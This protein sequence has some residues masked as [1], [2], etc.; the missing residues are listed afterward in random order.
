MLCGNTTC[1]IFAICFFLR[2]SS[3]SWTAP[4]EYHSKRKIPHDIQLWPHSTVKNWPYKSG[5][6]LGLND[7]NYMECDVVIDN[8]L[9]KQNTEKESNLDNKSTTFQLENAIL[10]R[11]HDDVIITN[12]LTAIEAC[13][14]FDLNSKRYSLCFGQESIYNITNPNIKIEAAYLDKRKT[15][16][17]YNGEVIQFFKGDIAKH[18]PDF[19]VYYAC[20]PSTAPISITEPIINQN[21]NKPPSLVHVYVLAP[22]FCD[23]RAMQV[24]KIDEESGGFLADTTSNRKIRYKD[25]R[26]S[27]LFGL[28]LDDLPDEE[29]RSY[30]ER[31]FSASGLIAHDYVYK[32]YSG[33]FPKHMAQQLHPSNIGL[34]NLLARLEGEC[35][36]YLLG[37]YIEYE[38]CHPLFTRTKNKDE[39]TW[40]TS[41]GSLFT[42]N[43][44]QLDDNV[45]EVTERSNLT[46]FN[47]TDNLHFVYMT[48]ENT[49]KWYIFPKTSLQTQKMAQILKKKRMEN[50]GDEIFELNGNI[51]FSYGL[52][53]LQESE[54]FGMEKDKSDEN[55]FLD[56]NSMLLNTIKGN[57][58][59][60]I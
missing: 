19:K 17:T 24:G 39:P 6:Q 48:H 29:E 35:F 1:K 46:H 56:R 36:R 42:S 58:K 7:G 52:G 5:Y 34:E 16:L 57:S 31:S 50:N 15:I 55:M 26:V 25:K 59:R 37:N 40:K 10:K 13:S 18:Q 54:K 21:S 47:D 53:S 2:L 23:L 30:I 4:L 32:Q 22:Y 38:Y 28:T 20:D 51:L 60:L 33:V 44:I 45:V 27:E 9:F 43:S 14:Q 3:A 11:V 49:P 12:K 8:E 41:L